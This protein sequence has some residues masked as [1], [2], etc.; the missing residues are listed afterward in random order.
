MGVHAVRQ[1]STRLGVGIAEKIRVSVFVQKCRC[2][3][4]GGN[5]QAVILPNLWLSG[6]VCVCLNVCECACVLR[7]IQ[8]S[9]QSLKNPS[10]LE[11][12][13]R[14]PAATTNPH[15]ACDLATP[16]SEPSTKDQKDHIT[17][18]L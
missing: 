14:R 7:L 18:F 3:L 15:E 2:D 4:Q 1:T 6:S 13:S 10:G 17:I 16:I 5:R 9:G 11:T 12:G 8:H